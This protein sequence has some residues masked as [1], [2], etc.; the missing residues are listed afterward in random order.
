[1]CCVHYSLKWGENQ[2]KGGNTC[3]QI[4]KAFAV[5]YVKEAC[6]N[7][8]L[9]A[10]FGYA[11]IAEMIACSSSPKLPRIWTARRPISWPAACR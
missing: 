2:E 9:Y 10:I 5:Y 7:A 4:L 11:I 6:G 3:A 1:M 8:Y